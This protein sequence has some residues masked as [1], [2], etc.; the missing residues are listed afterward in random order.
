MTA[1]F[2]GTSPPPPENPSVIFD[3]AAERVCRRC[4]LRTACWQQNYNATYNAFNDACPAMLRRGPPRRGT[5]RSISPRAV[6]T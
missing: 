4:V 1:F 6:S 5:F 2:R 3:R